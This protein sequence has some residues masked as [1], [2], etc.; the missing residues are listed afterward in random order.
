[1]PDEIQ[2]SVVVGVVFHYVVQ[3][4]H[5]FSAVGVEIRYPWEEFARSSG[6]FVKPH[7]EV[8]FAAVGKLQVEGIIRQLPGNFA[9]QPELV[10]FQLYVVFPDFRKAIHDIKSLGENFE[11]PE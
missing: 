3:Y 6:A 4:D 2:I 1:M 10:L 8:E 11:C 7:A 9:A 5:Q